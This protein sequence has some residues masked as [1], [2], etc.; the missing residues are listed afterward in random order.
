VEIIPGSITDPELCRRVV[1]GAT[2]VFHLAVAMREGGK[3]DEFFERVNLD[4]T[5][6]LL[7]AAA[8][9]GVTRFVHCSTIGIFGHRAPGVTRE[10]S[11]LAPGNVTADQVTSGRWCA[12]WRAQGMRCHPPAGGRAGP[13]QRQRS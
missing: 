3:Q 9:A 8:D 11:P 6:H 5:R 12:R 13:D 7:D 2:H 1:R 10:D 4:G